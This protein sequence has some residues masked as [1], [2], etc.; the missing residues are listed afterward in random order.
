MSVA[1]GEGAGMENSSICSACT[2]RGCREG[3]S[4]LWKDFHGA[5]KCLLIMSLSDVVRDLPSRNVENFTSF[6]PNSCNSL[7]A[8]KRTAYVPVKDIPVD[9]VII[10][11]RV[12]ILWG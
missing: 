3:A 11:K 6:N 1:W 9:Q 8:G 4:Q 12:S 2:K 5:L 7:S 10:N